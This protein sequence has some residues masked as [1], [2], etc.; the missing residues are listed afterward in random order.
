MTK[1]AFT[2][3]ELLVVIAIIGVLA[4][5]V[6]LSLANSQKKAGDTDRKTKAKSLATAL[7]QRYAATG[8][9]PFDSVNGTGASNGIDIQAGNGCA[10][11]LKSELVGTGTSKR[12]LETEASCVDKDPTVHHYYKSLKISP[13]DTAGKLFIIAWELK[14]K[15]EKSLTG[16]SS[17]DRGNGVY[18][19]RVQPCSGNLTGDSYFI[20]GTQGPVGVGTRITIDDLAPMAQTNYFVVYGPQ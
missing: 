3:I 4:A 2:L 15:S 7:E 13:S 12:Y 19:S 10:E 18:V 1:R 6:I 20:P 9:Y 17:T 5:L 11:P 8:G 16:C 14:N